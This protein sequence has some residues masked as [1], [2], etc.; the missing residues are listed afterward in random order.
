MFETNHIK[1]L[2][3][4]YPRITSFPHIAALLSIIDNYNETSTW[5]FSRFIQ[6]YNKEN[7]INDSVRGNFLDAYDIYNCPFLD[8]IYIERDN[9]YTEFGSFINFAI[10]YID[11]GYYILVNMDNFHIPHS[12]AY[13]SIHFRHETFIYGYDLYNQEFM[14]ADF[15]K[16][17]KYDYK[18]VNFYLIE[19]AFRDYHLTGAPIE[20]GTVGLFK[21][22]SVT[23]KVDTE[24]IR[25]SIS[26]YLASEDTT[27]KW[28]KFNR[29]IVFGI[30]YYDYFIN[31]LNSNIYDIRQA[32]IL[33][34]HKKAMVERVNFLGENN[35]L[36]NAIYLCSEYKQIEQKSVTLLNL[37]IKFTISKDAEILNRLISGYIDMAQI[38]RN[39]LFVMLKNLKNNNI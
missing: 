27:N 29:K 22:G 11:N 10:N 21:Y 33:M 35:L 17:N 9:V 23:F 16:G 28:D 30:A 3:V 37:L 15:Y 13:N 19:L 6:L 39:L 14:V 1:L 12:H 31:C 4:K 8:G 18:K 20:W 7:D 38:E 34:D 25:R 26:D 36:D 2:P 24:S 5:F 32:Y